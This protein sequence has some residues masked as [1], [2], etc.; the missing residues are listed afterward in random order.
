[1]QR[2][3]RGGIKPEPD[4]NGGLPHE[5]TE[6]A[7]QLL[8]E[9]LAGVPEAGVSA[10]STSGIMLAAGSSTA[11]GAQFLPHAR[12]LIVCNM[13]AAQVGKICTAAH[14]PQRVRCCLAA[15]AW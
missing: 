9:H 12:E 6:L 10:L 7:Q 8:L 15:H 13:L 1:M 3:E 14:V 11:V 2:A 4:A 5:V